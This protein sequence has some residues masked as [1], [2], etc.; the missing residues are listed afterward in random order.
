MFQ[1]SL[2]PTQRSTISAFPTLPLLCCLIEKAQHLDF[3]APGMTGH[4][5]KR[6]REWAAALGFP[7]AL[8][9]EQGWGWILQLKKGSLNMPCFS[10][11]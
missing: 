3:P 7:G 9:Q 4:F 11:R 6:H 2:S 10:V 8:S 1:L 5:S